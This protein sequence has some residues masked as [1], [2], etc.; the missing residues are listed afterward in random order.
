LEEILM[1]HPNRRLGRRSGLSLVEVLVALTIF[2]FALI[3][4]GRLITLSSDQALNV[5]QQGQAIQLCQAKLASV[6]AGALPLKSQGDVAFEDEP[7]WHWSLDAE[8]ASVAGL[9]NVTVR[10]NR[11]RPDG[12]KLEV[13]LSQMVLDP[14]LRGTNAITFTVQDS[15]ATNPNNVNPGSTTDNSG[16]TT[17]TGTTGA[18]AKPQS[19]GTTKGGNSSKTPSGGTT[20]PPAGGKTQPAGN[21]PPKGNPKGGKS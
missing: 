8:Q 14:T 12:S 15:T 2:L 21:T 11:T 17:P 4:I 13:S 19:G 7:N 6:V 16:T 1:K 9:W 10:V 20:K 18:G 3:G 5:E